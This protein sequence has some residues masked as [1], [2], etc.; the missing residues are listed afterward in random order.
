MEL[1]FYRHDG[2]TCLVTVDGEPTAYVARSAVV[3]LIEA[4]NTIIL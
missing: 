3:D 1:A 4:F 2:E